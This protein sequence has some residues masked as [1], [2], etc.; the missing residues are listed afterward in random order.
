VR[1]SARQFVAGRFAG[2]QTLVGTVV[3]ITEDS[4][5]IQVE[6]PTQ[7]AGIATG[8]TVPVGVAAVARLEVFRGTRT[9]EL[10]GALVGALV[11]LGVGIVMANRVDDCG[12]QAWICTDEMERYYW[13]TGGLNCGALAGLAVG[14]L[15]K[16]NRWKL[17]RLDAARVGLRAA[18][19]GRAAL[20]VSV[21]LGR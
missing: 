9:A 20:V 18:S 21:P 4:L 1:I 5:A 17:V 10:E 12:P 6:A 7:A 19:S 15:I 11:G 13:V 8:S 14:A 2:F 16:V 3:A